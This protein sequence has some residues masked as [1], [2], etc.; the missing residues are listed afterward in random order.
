[1]RALIGR[2]AMCYL[3]IKH[4]K[5]VLLF[6]AFRIYIIKQMKMPEPHISLL[7]CDKTFQAFKNTQEKKF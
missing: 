5:S 7:D 1:M 2:K 3:I 6:S 4:R